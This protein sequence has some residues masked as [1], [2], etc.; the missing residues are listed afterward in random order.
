MRD[1]VICM[2]EADF[3]HKT[4]MEMYHCYWSMGRIP[5]DFSVDDKVFIV[6][7]N[8]V[9]GYVKPLEF[10]PEDINGETI[11]W[12]GGSDFVKIKPIPCK[13]FRGFRYRWWN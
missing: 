6:T 8:H 2:R 9:V 1:I 3:L 13:P 11:V 7:K 12:D 4:D 10:N 5:R